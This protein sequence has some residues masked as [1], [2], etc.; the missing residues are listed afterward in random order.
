ML[1]SREE[2]IDWISKHFIVSTDS[3]S[4][5]WIPEYDL[6]NTHCSWFVTVPCIKV[7]WSTQERS[8]YYDWCL[9]NLQGYI[10]CFWTNKEE[11]KECWGFTEKND[12]EWWM[13]KWLK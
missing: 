2:F 1:Q 5:L 3:D 6:D 12:I 9:Q 11:N 7:S 10:R 4:P 13:L 8:I